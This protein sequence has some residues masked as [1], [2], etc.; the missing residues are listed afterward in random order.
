MSEK[1]RRKNKDGFHCESECSEIESLNFNR[2]ELRF[3]SIFM[4]C[5]ISSP[6]LLF[7]LLGLLLFARN[8][9]FIKWIQ[10]LIWI[11]F[12]VQSFHFQK[13]ICAEAEKWIFK[14]SFSHFHMLA[15]NTNNSRTHFSGFDIMYYT[16]EHRHFIIYRCSKEQSGKMA[17]TKLIH[18]F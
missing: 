17:Q 16:H 2:F 7:G 15:L 8:H 14:I 4:A 13:L 1:K 18:C 11:S 5:I 6:I 3:W 12:C 10:T 9:V